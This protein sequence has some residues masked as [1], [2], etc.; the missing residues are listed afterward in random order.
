MVCD[1]F[2][3]VKGSAHAPWPELTTKFKTHRRTEDGEDAYI[4][5]LNPEER[6]DDLNATEEDGDSVCEVR[7]EPGEVRGTPNGTFVMCTDFACF[8]AL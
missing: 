7:I 8:G 4:R 6:T 1:A 5:A 2:M 3:H